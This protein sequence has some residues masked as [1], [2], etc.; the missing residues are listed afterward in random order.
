VKKIIELAGM[1]VNVKPIAADAFKRKANVSNNETAI[2]LKLNQ[3]G[4]ASLPNWDESLEKYINT[5][6]K[7]WL[8][9]NKINE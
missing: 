7:S 5:H 6:L 4:Y 3:L 1:D 9:E 8:E 2:T